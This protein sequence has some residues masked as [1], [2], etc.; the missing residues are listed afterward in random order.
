MFARVRCCEDVYLGRKVR[1]K[2]R[3]TDGE[4]EDETYGTY[5][6]FEFSRG[7]IHLVTETLDVIWCIDDEDGV[8]IQVTLYG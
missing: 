8:F 3:R 7:T 1:G 2:R 4:R 6:K 5:A